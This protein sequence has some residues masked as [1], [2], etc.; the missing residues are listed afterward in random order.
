MALRIFSRR[1][2]FSLFWK[3]ALIIYLHL[4]G[5]TVIRGRDI[6]GIF[7]I[8]KCSTTK[9]TRNFLKRAEQSLAVTNLCE[10]LPRSFVVCLED[11][12]ERV[13]LSQISASTLA[14]RLRK[15]GGSFCRH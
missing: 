6:I 5:D 3:G 10:D 1:L 7:D 15:F 4:G 14:Q 13:Y 2:N 8:E 12:I 11:G 9:N